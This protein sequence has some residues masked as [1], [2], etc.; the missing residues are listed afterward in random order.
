VTP[1]ELQRKVYGLLKERLQRG[2]MEPFY[3]VNGKLWSWMHRHGVKW[4][5][6]GSE[7]FGKYAEEGNSIRDGYFGLMYMA[8]EKIVTRRSRKRPR[9]TLRPN[10]FFL[11]LPIDLVEKALALGFFP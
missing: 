8:D 1:E 2:K 10:I 5:K 9:A 4:I 6:S 3:A 11:E 7:W